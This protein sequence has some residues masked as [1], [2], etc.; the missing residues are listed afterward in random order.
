M[1]QH[2]QLTLLPIEAATA[3]ASPKLP[4]IHTDPFDRL[5]VALAGERA[6]TLVTPDLLIPKYPNV[7]T[8]W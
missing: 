4:G 8:V 6:L 7:K 2:H 5:L 1:I 3:I